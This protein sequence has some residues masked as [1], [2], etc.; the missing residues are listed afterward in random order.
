MPLIDQCNKSIES[1]IKIK[2]IPF[3]INPSATKTKLTYDNQYI[4]NLLEN[5]V[6]SFKVRSVI[7]NKN[8]K[9]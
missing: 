3:S 4:T 8:I 2:D 1:Y 6:Y 5:E 7:G 9:Y